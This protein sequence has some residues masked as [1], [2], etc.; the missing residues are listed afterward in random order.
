LSASDEARTV[1]ET[2]GV[3]GGDMF[4]IRTPELLLMGGMLLFFAS[5]V[6][7]VI[8]VAVRLALRHER[9]NSD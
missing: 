3:K 1:K 4:G 5:V 8:Y 2:V 6:G 7:G 9:K